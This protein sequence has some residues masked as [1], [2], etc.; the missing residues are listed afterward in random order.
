MSKQ[1]I[2]PSFDPETIRQE[3][4]FF[5]FETSLADKE[6]F[7]SYLFIRPVEIIQID[8][9]DHVESAFEHIDKYSENYYIAGYFAYEL[10]YF[11][12]DSLRSISGRNRRKKRVL[13]GKTPLIYAGV[14]DR[15]IEFDH[16]TGRWSSPEIN[17]YLL[18]P[19]GT[20]NRS[21]RNRAF[22]ITDLQPN[23]IQSA[24]RKDV[25]KI[26]GHIADGNTYQVNYTYKNKFSFTGCPLSLYEELKSTQYVPYSSFL[27]FGENSVLSLSPEL[28][29]RREDDTI[30]SKPMKGTMNR[31]KT[32][33][34]DKEKIEALKNSPK[35][36]AEN[37][38]IVDLIRNDIGKIAQWNTLKV[39]DLYRVEKYLTVLQMT[40][41]VSAQ[42]RKNVTYYEIFK[43][44]FP[45][46]SITGA[47]KIRTMQIIREMEKEPRNVYC[48]AIGIIFPGK[49]AVFNVPIR[50]VMLNGGRGEMGIGSGIVADSEPDKELEECRL[51]SNFL[52]NRFPRFKL[53]E[54]LLWDSEY[55]FLKEHAD[56]I[57]DSA[58]YFDYHIEQ[59]TLARDL[60][61]LENCFHRGK[62]YKIR[63][64]LDRS[65]AM[66]YEHALLEKKSP[67]QSKEK[68]IALSEIRTD[69]DNIFFYHK[70]DNRDLYDKEYL[71][72]SKQ[73]YYEVVFRNFEDEITEGAISNIFIYKN[74]TYFTPPIG[75]GILNGIYRAHFM[76]THI[77]EE[78][79]LHEKDLHEADALYVCNS[80]RGMNEVTL[81]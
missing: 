24:Y 37:T 25:R 81:S 36:L 56:R 62:C 28:F 45:C 20:T 38:M 12:E 9:V 23:I 33:L 49:K 63:I 14:F 18:S 4:L 16:R 31:G 40:S 72:Y 67:E 54:T 79:I 57:R 60:K 21:D 34:E 78:K 68:K 39:S 10:G 58:L 59:E 50:T 2:L 5:L 30:V 1:C 22:K 75:S 32:N 29:F 51:K 11:F 8:D 71:R 15:V 69:K 46:G 17:R 64:L 26:L 80:V 13:P 53:L 19:E 48:G 66:H 3:P 55:I 70:T 44:L 73:G 7:K 77:V 35:D 27:K 42:L 76:K 65:G 41:T 43:S 47:P 52:V 6:N 61:K 74:G